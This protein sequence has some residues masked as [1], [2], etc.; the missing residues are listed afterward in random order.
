LRENVFNGYSPSQQFFVKRF[1]ADWV[2]LV[3]RFITLY[4]TKQYLPFAGSAGVRFIAK[5]RFL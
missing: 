3:R 4:R 1:R 5:Y 2:G